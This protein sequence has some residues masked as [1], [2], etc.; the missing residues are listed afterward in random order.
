MMSLP[1]HHIIQT[2]VQQPRKLFILDA[3][4]AL[5]TAVLLV[6]FGMYFHRFIGLPV[7]ILQGLS[8]VAIAICIYSGICSICLRDHW[9][10]F[11]KAMI[12]GNLAY[13][14]L[15]AWI[16]AYYIGDLTGWGLV[17]FMGEIGVIGMLVWLEVRVMR[18][19]IAFK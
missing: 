7:H 11:I 3:I 8:L 18:E 13:C 9:R 4:G 2:F 19:V 12:I 10:G 6:L 17:Y 15:T 14:G 1:I 16:V 5:L